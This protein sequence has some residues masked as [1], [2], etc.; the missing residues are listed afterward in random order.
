MQ[1]EPEYPEHER[2][3]EGRGQKR[4][5]EGFN[6]DREARAGWRRGDFGSQEADDDERREISTRGRSRWNEERELLDEDRRDDAPRGF[7]GRSERVRYIED[8]AYERGHARRG[9]GGR[10]F[11]GMDP[12]QHREISR[13]G[14]EARR[15]ASQGHRGASQSKRSQ[16][17]HPARKSGRASHPR[18]RR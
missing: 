16:T 6:E 13:R 11:A 17:S 14:G 12:Q 10:G 1:H 15:G 4:E 3:R 7:S 5:D 18:S 8:E 9:G 2:E